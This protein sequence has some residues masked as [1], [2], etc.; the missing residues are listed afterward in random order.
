LHLLRLGSTVDISSNSMTPKVLLYW[1]C[2]MTVAFVMYTVF[3]AGY[4]E[5]YQ[6]VAVR[7]YVCSEHAR[8]GGA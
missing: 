6:L 3:L 2:A 8:R 4:V 1:W 5:L 7:A